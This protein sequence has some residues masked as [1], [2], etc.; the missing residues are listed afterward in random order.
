MIMGNESYLNFRRRD[1][2]LKEGSLVDELLMGKKSP[3]LVVHQ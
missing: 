2:T 1:F 3:I